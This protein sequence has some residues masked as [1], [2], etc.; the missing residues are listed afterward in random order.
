MSYDTAAEVSDRLVAGMRGGNQQALAEVFSAYRERLKRIVRFRLD[1][2]LARRVSDSDVLQDTYIAAAKRLEHFSQHP[3]MSPFLWLRL[4]IGQQLI[5]VHRHHLQAEMRDV[6]KE[7]SLQQSQ[8]SPHTSLAIAAKLVGQLTAVSELVA[9]AERIQRLEAT[10]N[11]MD[12]TD[13][14]VIALRHFEELSNLET[15]GVLNIEPAAASKR[16]IRA[17]AKLGQLMARFNE[18]E[19]R[20]TI[21]KE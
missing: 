10:L 13:R 14:E 2:R 21:D 5:D 20:N 18:A 17:M 16:Y 9:R 6:R 3:E 4:L 19:H 12:P 11:G 7:V 8:P 1:Y 15:A